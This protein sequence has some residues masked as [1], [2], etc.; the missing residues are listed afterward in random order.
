[1]SDRAKVEADISDDNLRKARHPGSWGCRIPPLAIRPV[2]GLGAPTGPVPRPGAELVRDSHGHR[3]GADAP[4]RAS[5]ILYVLLLAAWGHGRHPHRARCRHRPPVPPG[6]A[7]P[8][9]RRLTR[10]GQHAGPQPNL[11]SPQ[12]PRGHDA[13]NT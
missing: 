11:P 3:S 1:M 7:R 10:A 6:G 2:E 9:A 12:I 4:R 8:A 5:I 13:R